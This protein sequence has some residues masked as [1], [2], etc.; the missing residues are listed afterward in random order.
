MAADFRLVRGEVPEPMDARGEARRRRQAQ[1]PR[2]L[3]P[4]DP[5]LWRPWL[6]RCR[7]ILADPEAARA[8][9]VVPMRGR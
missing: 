3:D 2:Q 6:A 4:R 1:P 8:R 5:R 9:Q 7:E